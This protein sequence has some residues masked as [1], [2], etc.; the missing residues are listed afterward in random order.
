VANLDLASL[1]IYIVGPS[2]GALTAVLITRAL[3]GPAPPD[4]KSR[5]AAEGKH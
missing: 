2:I 1:W 5:E 4:D 3:R